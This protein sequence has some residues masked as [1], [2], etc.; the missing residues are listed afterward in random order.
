MKSYMNCNETLTAPPLNQSQ[1]LLTR[2]VRHD[3]PE[4]NPSQML[5]RVPP[6]LKVRGERM[7]V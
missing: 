6:P 3:R 2:L 1:P 5:N 4:Q 7:P